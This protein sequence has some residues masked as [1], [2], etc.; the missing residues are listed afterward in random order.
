MAD[1][2]GKVAVVTGASK[3]IGAAIANALAAAG[4][5]VVVNYAGAMEA[6]SRVVADIV[7]KGGRAIAVQGDVS[8]VADVSRLFAETK[9]A[10]GTIDILVNN[11]GI[12]GFSPL[13]GVTEED[14]RRLF[15]TNV[16]GAILTTKEALTHFGPN[17]GSVINIG[18]VA[19]VRPTPGSAVYAATKGAIETL[20]RALAAEL[21]GRRIR[22]NTLAPG[23][24][25]TE[26]TRGAGLIGSE[27]EKQI[28][29][30]TPLGRLGQPDDVARVVF[31][32]S[33]EAG[34]VTGAFIPA[35]GGLR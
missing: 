34:W 27:F 12:G 9:A 35:S 29:A 26:A 11:A 6:A 18:S 33:D 10:F 21:G 13:E 30:G 14:Y 28:V 23:P 20:T 22:V 31:L 3:G 19:N 16:L 5:A 32:A 2:T 4:A 17:G 8:K 1:L 15:D 24:V 7:G 25:D